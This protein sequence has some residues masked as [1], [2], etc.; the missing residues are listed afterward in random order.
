MHVLHSRRIAL[1]AVA[2][3]KQCGFAVSSSDKETSLHVVSCCKNS[4]K[5]G[6]SNGIGKKSFVFDHE[7]GIFMK[8]CQKI[9][10][11]IIIILYFCSQK[12]NSLER[13][14]NV[15]IRKNRKFL[16]KKWKNRK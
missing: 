11:E 7:D 13:E 9:Y 12:Y 10:G 14:R 6:F 2:I 8:K 15:F 4:E 5:S 3:S 16:E 1:R